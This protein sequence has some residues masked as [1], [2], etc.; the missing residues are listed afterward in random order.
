[1]G[2]KINISVSVAAIIL[3]GM[4][5]TGCDFLRK[6]AGRPTSA[7]LEAA[8]A[9]REAQEQAQHQ[10]RLD[11]ARRVAQAV[12]DSLKAV[13]TQAQAVAPVEIRNF[14]IV[15]TFSEPKNAEKKKRML[16]ADGYKVEI[17]NFRSGK[18]GV[19]IEGAV[20]AAETKRV[21]QELI[22]KGVCSQGSWILEKH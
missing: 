13:Q 15:G 3:V 10:A 5:A 20:T 11:S 19:G 21:M 8:V 18:K 1:M 4:A 14:I 7:Q 6:V 17:F 2:M 22:R 9:V 16:E 12:E